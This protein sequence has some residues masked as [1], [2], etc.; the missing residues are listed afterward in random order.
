MSAPFVIDMHYGPLVGHGWTVNDFGNTSVATVTADVADGAYSIPVSGNFGLN[1]DVLASYVAADGEYHSFRIVSSNSTTVFSDRPLKAINSGSTVGNVY[2]NDAHPNDRGGAV[3]VDHALRALAADGRRVLRT[4][5]RDSAA[6]SSANALLSNTPGTYYDYPAADLTG[7]RGAIVSGS[8][9]GDAVSASVDLPVGSFAIETA[10]NTGLNGSAEHVLTVVAEQRDGASWS[11]LVTKTIRGKNAT[12]L[13][14][15][16][17]TLAAAKT[18]RLRV[19]TVA[20]SAWTFKL[21]GINVYRVTGSAPNFN[22]GKHVLL[23]DSW[24][25]PTAPVPTRLIARLSSA[26]VVVKGVNGN[27]SDQL[28]SRFA[29]DVAAENPAFVWVMCG[30][31]DFYQGVT[32]EAFNANIET[33]KSLINGIGAQGIFFT[34]SVG[35]IT[36]SPPQFFP[37]RRLEAF[38]LYHDLDADVAPDPTTPD[39]TTPTVPVEAIVYKKAREIWR[40]FEID[41]DASSGYHEV[42]PAD[43]RDWGSAMEAEL[44]A[45]PQPSIIFDT[46]SN[47]FATLAYAAN[48]MAWVASDPVAANNGIYM[49]SGASGAGSWTKKENLSYSVLFATDAASGNPNAIQATT[50]VPI[51]NTMLVVV[52][53]VSATTSRD[54][55]V[56]LNGGPTLAIKTVLGNKPLI[57]ALKAGMLAVGAIDG[58]VF[59]LVS[60]QDSSKIVAAAVAFKDAAVSGKNDFLAFSGSLSLPSLSGAD[61]GKSLVV[62]SAGNGYDAKSAIAQ[63]ATQTTTSGSSKDFAIPTWASRIVVNV[64][65]VSTTGVGSFIL[66]LGTGGVPETSGY[67]GSVFDEVSSYLFSTGVGF[68]DA[69]TNAAI[70]RHGQFILDLVDRA[71][72]TWTVSFDIGFS[73]SAGT[74]DGAGSKTLAGAL[75]IIR[76]LTSDAFDAGSVTVSYS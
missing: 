14:N 37:S 43:V 24:F 76:V 42:D 72:N 3:V 61:T 54:V 71:T 59:R 21:G 33:L 58:S 70:I 73:N 2:K 41:G 48:T 30:T 22:T 7:Y 68:F 10:I 31:N 19:S 45:S 49:K 47:L 27:R 36:F 65:G 69:A 1:A 35:A 4:K 29:A 13:V 51:S 63:T 18:V 67:L 34:P 38:T 9:A 64:V 55:T 62:N 66:Q 15:L 26:T 46:R 32:P 8:A 17:F 60:D 28:I 6:W 39:P 5:L 16:T 20:T 50:G 12:H 74:R 23:G 53:I 56:S 52:P 57:G 40:D 44:V 11:T 75:N 25:F